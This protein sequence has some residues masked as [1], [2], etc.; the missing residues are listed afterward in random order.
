MNATAEL[1][2]VE[3]RELIEAKRYRELREALAPLPPFD[4][5][6]VL[7]LLD[8]AEAAV[9][10]RLLPRELAG[11]A[12]AV[13]DYD[14]EQA[15]IDALGD[16]SARTM[17]QAM[18]P[19]DRAA[20]LDEMPTSAAQRLLSQLRPEDRAVTQQILGYPEESVGRLMTPDYVRLR[21]EWTIQQALEHIRRY[22]KDAETVHW[23]YVIDG[24]GKLI[25]DL[26]IRSILLA[27]PNQTVRDVM[28][29][30]Y[31]ALSATDDQEQAA[32]AMLD[33][34]RTVLPVVDTKGILLGIVTIDDVADV[35]EEEATEDIQLLGGMEAL[36]DPYIKTSLVEM[37]RK[38]GIALG[39]LFV[40]QVVTIAILGRF[41]GA[42]EAH[43]ILAMLVP[44]MISCGG[45]TGTQAAS[46]LIRAV[47]LREVSP[48]DWRRVLRKE[49]VTGAILGLAL[50]VM[51][52]GIVLLVDA[53]GL[54]STDEPLRVGVAVGLAV[55][56]I[57]T[58]A[59]MLGGLLPLLLE[60]LKLD[61]ATI[62]S[63]LVATL[64]DIS[65]I[66]IY[67]GV[68]TVVLAGT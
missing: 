11:E 62:S 26:H 8:P 39:V 29:D 44:L 59:A 1:L 64:M 23:V 10:F 38:R 20:L 40:V 30:A 17:L 24:T 2:N 13:L 57:V 48:R 37:L 60:K 47:S 58:W 28:D 50:G 3:V 68:A 63:P 12:F 61:P 6:A 41:E 49:L 52:V 33:Y 7:D 15:I 46:L 35:V 19:D 43:L 22:G 54:A 67:L 25:D 45:N 21:P 14:R 18:D 9:A 31:L 56:G 27:E 4:V 5:A 51:G 34:D 53:V 42:L 36:D 32:R 66:L 16:R 55:V 65:G